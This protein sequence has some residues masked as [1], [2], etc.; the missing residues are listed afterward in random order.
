MAEA[1]LGKKTSTFFLDFDKDARV[2]SRDI[3]SLDPGS[4]ESAEADWGGLTGF[5]SRFMN[6][7]SAVVAEEA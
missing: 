2:T 5:S 4:A 1:A 6:A 3:S 7:V